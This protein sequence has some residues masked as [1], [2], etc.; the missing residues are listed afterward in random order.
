MKDLL[1]RLDGAGDPGGG[2]K[3]RRR[4]RREEIDFIVNTTHSIKTFAAVD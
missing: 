4:R 2:G 3:V 1:R